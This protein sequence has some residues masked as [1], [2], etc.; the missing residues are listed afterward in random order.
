MSSSADNPF[1]SSKAAT[2]TRR[3]KQS[4]NYTPP[5]PVTASPWFRWPF[6][7]HAVFKW[8]LRGWYPL[9]ERSIILGFALVSWWLLPP[10]ESMQ[11]ISVGWAL[12]IYS[13]NVAL[14]VLVAGG[15]HCYFYI[16]RCQG[17]ELRFDA[18][19]FKT[20]NRVFTF[21]SQVLDNV[22]WTLASG[23][24]VWTAYEVLMLWA[25][26][27][28][29]LPTLSLT[30]QW[31]WLLLIIFLLPMWE[32]VHFFVIHRVIHE[33]PLYERIHAL[34]HRNT[35]VGP[36]SGLSMHPA[37]HVI[38]LSTVLIHFIVP[39]HP[40]IIIFHL[41]YFT[42]SAATTHTGYQGIIRYRKMLL[43]L[44][45]FHHQMHHR[46]FQC[47]YG[48]LEVPLD[49]WTGS[50]HDGTAES[51]QRFLEQRKKKLQS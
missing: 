44:G 37:E 42:L 15:L 45:T 8:I 11:T 32:T 9:T 16:W 39:A 31:P 5:L 46:Y 40:I 13:R 48:G 23:V 49:Q 51:H 43:P 22:F 25:L 18:R 19:P 17:D 6:D 27:N 47:N 12:G 28:G 35:N 33:V 36:W 34:H 29:Y 26:A 20:N 21:R 24:T 1:S 10:I 38:Y 30:E 3:G 41:M 50:F 4:W 2:T 7:F 14:M